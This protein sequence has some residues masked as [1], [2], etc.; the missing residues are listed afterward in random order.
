MYT[1]RSV[2][3]PTATGR[4]SPAAQGGDDPALKRQRDRDKMQSSKNRTNVRG[5]R[6]GSGAQPVLEKQHREVPLE[7]R[8]S[9]RQCAPSLHKLSRQNRLPPENPLSSLAGDRPLIPGAE[10]LF[11]ATTAS[12]I[13]WWPG[14]AG[15]WAGHA[16]SPRL[17]VPSATCC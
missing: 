12:S 7:L 17:P 13:H 4:A 2:S 8:P 6:G 15:C 9:H 14:G 11:T 3:E 5:S 16:G 1:R 10:A